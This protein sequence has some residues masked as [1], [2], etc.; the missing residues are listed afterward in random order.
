MGAERGRE[1]EEIEVTP[2]MIAAGRDVIAG[3][4]TDFTGPT[5]GR[6]WAEVLTGV[7]RAMTEVQRKSSP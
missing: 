1:A 7:F 3:V 2:E 4:W 6:L 5:G